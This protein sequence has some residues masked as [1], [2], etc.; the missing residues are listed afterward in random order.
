ME[1]WG[2][3]VEFVI[4][5]VGPA[6]VLRKNCHVT[7]RVGFQRQIGFVFAKCQLHVSCQVFVPAFSIGELVTCRHLN[8]V[9][10]LSSSVLRLELRMFFEA[11]GSEVSGSFASMAFLSFCWTVGIRRAPMVISST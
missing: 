5:E 2:V 1:G 10:P 8:H 11:H 6:Y 4:S 3:L 9:N 7:A